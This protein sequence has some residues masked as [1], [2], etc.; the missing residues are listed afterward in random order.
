VNDCELPWRAIRSDATGTS[1]AVAPG[2]VN[3]VIARTV[4]GMAR[5]GPGRMPPGAWFLAGGGAEA[6]ALKGGSWRSFLRER[7]EMIFGCP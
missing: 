4:Q 7:L 1:S 6:P 3:L 2:I 5:A